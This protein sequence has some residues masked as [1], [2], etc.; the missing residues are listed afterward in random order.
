[1]TM[2]FTKVITHPLGLTGFALALVFGVAG[3]FA[4]SRRAKAPKWLPGV[5]VT[6]AAVCLVGGLLLA[7][8]ELKTKGAASAAV[9][10]QQVG[11]GN[12]AATHGDCAP[13]LAGVAVGGSL[14]TNCNKPADGQQPATGK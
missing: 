10:Y 11:G 1:M 7:R 2:D 14:S 13:A 9:P 4:H 5:A 8:E 3:I 6:L 12:A